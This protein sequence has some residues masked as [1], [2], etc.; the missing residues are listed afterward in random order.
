MKRIVYNF[1]VLKFL[2]I[3]IAFIS[4]SILN[5]NTVHETFRKNISF[6]PGGF[7]S[8]E[9]T[10]GSVEVVSWDKNEIEI[11]AYKEVRAGDR[12]TA[13]KLMEKIEIDIRE[14]ENEIIIKTHFP[15]SSS[16]NGLF[17]WLFGKG[18]NS[19]SVEYE[20]KVPENI[21]LN[22]HTTNGGVIVDNIEGR[23]RL[24]TTNG[25]IRGRNIN[26]LAR[27]HT[28]NGSIRMEFTDIPADEKL[29][30]KT[31]NGSIKLYLPENFGGEAE[32]KTTNGR[33]DSDFSL[34]DGRKKSK[35]RYYGKIND[36][37]NVL[38]CSTTNGSIYLYSGD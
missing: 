22:L 3:I 19:I 35:K 11:V 13:E 15:K 9:N 23:L 38:I 27:C 17:G 16:S 28:T 5:A 20:I 29:S 14:S 25:K 34:S 36:G 10:N 1:S 30:F 7:L 31:T 6:N 33:I 2:I 21:D 32:L 4:S 24:E 37:D 18:G 8:L 26:G 12:S